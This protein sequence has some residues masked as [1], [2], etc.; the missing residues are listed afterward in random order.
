MKR[1]LYIVEPSTGAIFD[2]TEHIFLV[3]SARVPASIDALDVEEWIVDH[4]QDIGYRLD[5]YNMNNLFFGGNN[6]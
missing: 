1:Y 4:A 3:D 5:N 6:E 2:L